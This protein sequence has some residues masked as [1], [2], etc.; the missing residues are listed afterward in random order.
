MLPEIRSS[1]EVYGE[2]RGTLA[3]VPVAGALGDQQAALFG[4][5]CFAPGE[6]KCTYGTGSFLLMNMGERSVVSASGLLTTLAA[7]VGD[8]PPTYAFEGSAGIPIATGAALADR[9]RSPGRS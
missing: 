3:G 5:A 6:A 1:A 4:Q 7:R 8:E 9:L 2:A